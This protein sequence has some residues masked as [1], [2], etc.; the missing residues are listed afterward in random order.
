M[1]DGLAVTQLSA[2]EW[3]VTHLASGRRISGSQAPGFP[4]AAM[5]Q[6]VAE[7]LLQL[8]TDWEQSDTSQLFDSTLDPRRVRR[9]IDWALTQP[10]LPTNQELQRYFQSL[11]S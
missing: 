6:R 1:Q 5:A 3:A 9:A 11:A 7:W 4:S 10:R 2:A 8:P